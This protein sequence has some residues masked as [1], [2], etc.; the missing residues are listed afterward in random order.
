MNYITL[1]LASSILFLCCNTPNSESNEVQ[2]SNF[3]QFIYKVK[4]EKMPFRKLDGNPW[5]IGMAGGPDVFFKI[6]ENGQPIFTSETRKDIEFEEIPLTWECHLSISDIRA[7]YSIIFSDDD[8]K[9]DDM[10]SSL[11]FQ[12]KNLNSSPIILE[13]GGVRASLF[14]E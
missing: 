7:H 11:N 12:A 9:N 4:L 8:L 6:T 1:I 14:F 3:S 2:Q 5:D 10:I 13:T